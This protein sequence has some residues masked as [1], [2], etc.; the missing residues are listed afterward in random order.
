MSPLPK[1]TEEDF[2]R[3]SHRVWL[4][5]RRTVGEGEKTGKVWRKWEKRA[6]AA[7]SVPWIR[8]IFRGLG[9]EYS[10]FVEIRDG[11]SLYS[12]GLIKIS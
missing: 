7:A 11:Y 6:R 9:D 8:A 5:R 3:K 10:E 1:Q 2:S 12:L 4:R